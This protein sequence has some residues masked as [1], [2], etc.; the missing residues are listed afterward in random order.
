MKKIFKTSDGR[1]YLSITQKAEQLFEV[2]M[3]D[4][5]AVWEKG[6]NVFRLPILEK[7]D[8]DIAH[9]YDKSICIEIASVQDI[10]DI[11][12]MKPDKWD[13]AD[14]VLHNGFI[15]IRYDDLF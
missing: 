14:K 9:K 12:P 11:I 3:F 6:D 5:Y 13:K 4:M 7:E 2:G 10:I 15:Y 1:I 8:I